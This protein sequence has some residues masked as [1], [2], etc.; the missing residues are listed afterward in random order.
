[1]T[2]VFAQETEEI[3]TQFE[4]SPVVDLKINFTRFPE[5]KPKII[6]QEP[7]EVIVTFSNLGN[8]VLNVT[9]IAAS[10]R[11]PLLFSYIIQ[12]FS[13][14][15]VNTLVQPNQE[16]NIAHTF[17]PDEMLEERDFGLTI[18]VYYFDEQERLLASV[19]FNE[20]IHVDPTANSLDAKA[21]FTIIGILAFFGLIG[22][23]AFTSFAPAGKAGKSY[24]RDENRK[25]VKEDDD[26]LPDYLKKRN[27]GEGT[28]NKNKSKD[29]GT[30]KK[31]K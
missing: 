14:G 27:P 21:V 28:E 13:V 16:I 11:H 1:L 20:T 4:A 3:E 19:A 6:A 29:K 26:W 9:A 17:E 15:F 30:K 12:N 25:P 22:Y 31:T 10:I 18:L 2:C 8:E 24:V 5:E 23:F 7:N